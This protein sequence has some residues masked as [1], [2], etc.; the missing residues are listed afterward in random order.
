VAETE[1]QAVLRDSL[2]KFL[3]EHYSF[4][5]RRALLAGPLRP[6]AET[7]KALAEELGVLGVGFDSELSGLGAGVIETMLIME[8]FGRHL[9]LEPFLETV[10][11]C[12]GLLRRSGSPAAKALIRRIIQGEAR[13]AFAY[14][15]PQGRY[16]LHDVALS[17]EKRAGGFVLSGHKSA[18]AGGPVADAVL[19][20]ARTHGDRRDR[21]GISLFLV[22]AASAGVERRDYRTI[23][24]RPAS[25]IRL[26]G[27]EVGA[28][29]LLQEEALP[30]VEQ[31]IDEA[32]AAVCAE[33]AGALKRL[34]ETTV[35]YAIQRRQ[36]GAPIASFQALQ[37]RMV[38]ML[39]SVEKAASLAVMATH[40]LDA[41]PAERAMAVSA[42]KAQVGA[43]CRFVGQNA[44]Q[45]HGAIGIT[46]E[47]A[48]SHLFK[49]LMVIEAQFGSTD[50]HLRRY[51]RLS[52]G[53]KDAAP[54][55]RS[56]WARNEDLSAEDRAFRDE[57]RAFLAEKFDAELRAQTARQAGVFAEGALT[58]RWHRILYE[59][60]W[61][62]PAWPREYGGPGWTANQRAIFRDEC[63]RVGVPSLPAMGLTL[64]GPV[65]MKYGTDEQRA[66]F[67]PR[68]LSGEHYWCQGF[69]EPQ[70]GSDLASLQTRAVRDGEDYVVNG[71]KI[72]TTHA[73]FANW[74]FLL[75][76]T[77]T[78]GRPQ[79]G[80]SFFVT[81]LDAP[82]IT[83][84]PIISMS[85]EH[86][87]NQIFFDDLRIPAARRIGPENEG[88]NMA[89]YLLEFERGGSS[90]VG[91]YTAIDRLRA[92]A[93]QAPDDEGGVMVDD[94]DF[95]R[96]IAK[97]E[98]DVLALDWLERR[99]AA[100]LWVS[101][102][103]IAAAP[104]IKK[105]MASELSQQIAELAM[106]ALGVY[107]AADQRTALG[108]GA[109]EPPIGPDYAAVATARYLN[110]R[111]GTIFG[112]SSEVQKNIL[113]RMVLRL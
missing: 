39:V 66:F 26:H 84:R 20:T 63:S 102:G 71:S 78:E 28:D 48:A 8:A 46:D 83:V 82:G 103:L 52:L 47:L 27:V 40:Q 29:A 43:A 49:R 19:V 42:A 113:A 58:R 11:L 75:V 70:S 109:S 16:C 110:G 74:I 10:V 1:E 56:G 73:H 104:S 95:R 24:G 97:V 89:K 101:E 31:A 96:K 34:L 99:M 2:S 87:I 33:A 77:S 60:G 80:I 14:A 62:A 106:E 92:I 55:R 7:W 68:M 45:L 23:D 18:V 5:R 35:D 21:S 36:F 32:T 91:Q 13:L 86:E 54:V 64:C 65:I 22:D 81:P 3:S 88:W 61:V 111:A 15:E 72:W 67:L 100:D 12:G 41:A 107:G 30:V 44:I 6:D 69:S 98:V 53:S 112:G 25:E 59:Q 108:L 90:A 57:V 37:H 85:G 93:A 94:P 38:D 76:R 9:V 79:A 50:H 4:E 51:E 17:A 105:L